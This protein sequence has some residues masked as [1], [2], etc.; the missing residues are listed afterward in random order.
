MRRLWWRI[1]FGKHLG[2]GAW[3]REGFFR[4]RFPAIFRIGY[5]TALIDLDRGVLDE[6]PVPD[7]AA[8]D[9]AADRAWERFKR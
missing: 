2:A 8:A 1:K 5:R 9:E 4:Y 7:F 3:S 6:N